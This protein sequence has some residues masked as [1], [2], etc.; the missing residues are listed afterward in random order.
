MKN[1]KVVEDVKNTEFKHKFRFIREVEE[2]RGV[3]IE[4]M[5]Y[6]V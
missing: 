2:F 4:S 5:I 6:Y 1:M 3:Q